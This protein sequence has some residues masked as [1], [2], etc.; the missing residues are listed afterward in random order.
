MVE[1]RFARAGLSRH[2]D[3]S[4]DVV[5]TI[6][7]CTASGSDFGLRGVIAQHGHFPFARH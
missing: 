5:V 3:L 7:F 4:L 6:D 1:Y 2:Q